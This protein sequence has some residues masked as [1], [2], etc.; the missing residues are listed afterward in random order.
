MYFNNQIMKN[1]PPSPVLMKKAGTIQYGYW[2]R[3]AH[4][5]VFSKTLPHGDSNNE[6]RK[7][8]ED[9]GK[10]NEGKKK[11]RREG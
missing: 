8:T 10:R 6:I 1:H 2:I 4:A 7:R 5:Q 9:E 3:G 11:V